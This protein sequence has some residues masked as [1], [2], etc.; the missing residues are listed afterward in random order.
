MYKHKTFSILAALCLTVL[1]FGLFIAVQ[2]L[3]PQPNTAPSPEETVPEAVTLPPSYAVSDTTPATAPDTAPDTSSDTAPVTAS[4]TEPESAPAVTGEAIARHPSDASAGSDANA[5]KAAATASPDVRPCSLLVTDSGTVCEMDIEAFVLGALIAEMPA[6]FHSEA[7]KAQA[8]AI[9]TFALRKQQKFDAGS[10]PSAHAGAA[11]CTSPGHCC[12]YYAPADYLADHG[13]IAANNLPLFEEAVNATAGMIVTYGGE[14]IEAVFH[15]SSH[16][17]TA[18]SEEVWGGFLPYLVS[19]DTPE[20][21]RITTKVIEAEAWAAALSFDTAEAA[22]LPQNGL[23]QPTVTRTDSGR[24]A[25]V[26]FGGAVITGARLRS[27][28]KLPSTQFELSVS[29]GALTVVCYGSGHGVGMSQ[30]GADAL[31]KSGYGWREILLHY[32]VGCE[33]EETA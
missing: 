16:Q 17:K 9:R 1:F 15:S 24:A 11:L 23:S 25:Q 5:R 18:G 7:L 28:L 33:I 14:P 10:H 12:A 4:K 13:I 26:S 6:D 22:K 3:L 32:Y 29:G 19:V 8:V 2:K 27:A 21:G 31:G 20:T 30:Y